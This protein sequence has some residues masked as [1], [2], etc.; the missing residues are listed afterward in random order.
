M[1]QFLTFS[2]NSQYYF[3]SL[4]FFNASVYSTA[5]QAADALLVYVLNELDRTAKWSE[6]YLCDREASILTKY[7]NPWCA[8]FKK[9]S[10]VYIAGLTDQGDFQNP[11]LIGRRKVEGS[12]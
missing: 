1:K 6:E 12:S 10:R 11:T 7:G 9:N 5:E 2:W 4:S 8:I 3:L